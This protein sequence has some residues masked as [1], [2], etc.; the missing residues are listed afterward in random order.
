[1]KA[2]TF[3]CS[4]TCPQVSRAQCKFSPVFAPIGPSIVNSHTT[5]VYIE[6][7]SK[8]ALQAAVEKLGGSVL[9]EGTYSLFSSRH[10]GFA[11]KLPG[12]TYPIIAGKD[13]ALHYDSYNGQWGNESDVRLLTGQYAIEA[14]RQAALAQGWVAQDNSD[15]LL[16]YHP[17]GG[18]I[19]VKADGTVES[20]GFVGQGCD[21]ATV[22]EQALGGESVRT[23]KA[24]YFAERA[25]IRTQES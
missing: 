18:T 10:T 7:R 14:A 25:V 13:G 22:I 11:F 12:W 24:E 23:N 6:F 3:D 17:T 15:G 20:S 21:A 2:L 8:D 16:I 9:G 5:S 19:Q 4:R 1:M